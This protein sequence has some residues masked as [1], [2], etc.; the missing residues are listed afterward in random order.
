M[1][2]TISGSGIVEANLADNA[3]TLAK[4]AGGTDGEILT[5]DA[6]GNPVAVSVGTDGQV[7]TSTGAG[8]PPAFETA[9]GGGKVLQVIQGKL[10][11][12]FTTSS[13]TMVDL[14]LSA[15]ITPASTSKILVTVHMT[16]GS[17]VDSSDGITQLVRGSTN[18]GLPT[19]YGSRTASFMPLNNRGIGAHEC[20]TISNSF[21]DEPST[22][23]ATTYKIQV[24]GG[25]AT[26]YINRGSTD[27]DA[28][29]E[30][31]HISTITLMEIGA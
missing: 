20:Y 7:L 13:S 14:G 25:G 2:I 16:V 1:A 30:S 27:D 6:S 22:S 31:R 24:S 12:S 5:Y 8:S 29:Y 11:T 4:M 3:V 28:Y 15:T 23:S 18:I 9:A 26:Q 19:S 21:L 10:T 17:D